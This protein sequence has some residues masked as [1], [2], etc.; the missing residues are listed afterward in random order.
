MAHQTE[1]PFHMT[2]RPR[3]PN[4]KGG[5]GGQW[6]IM[7]GNQC[8]SDVLV[9]LVLCSSLFKHRLQN[10]GP[11]QDLFLDRWRTCCVLDNVS[12]N[13]CWGTLTI[14]GGCCGCSGSV[15]TVTQL[16]RHVSEAGRQKNHLAVS[17]KNMVLQHGTLRWHPNCS[18]IS[19][20]GMHPG[21]LQNVR[22]APHFSICPLQTVCSIPGCLLVPLGLC[23]LLLSGFNGGH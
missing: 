2:C 13:C 19:H 11:R 20:F 21:C 7:Q 10:M 17:T 5:G 16:S 22:T 15:Q 6:R 18:T 14:V 23:C 9:K 1:C 8:P 12:G 4:E 3:T